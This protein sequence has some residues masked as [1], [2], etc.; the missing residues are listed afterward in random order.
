MQTDLIAAMIFT[1]EMKKMNNGLVLVVSGPAG[2]GKGTVNKILRETG[3]YLFSVSRTTRA[4]RP[5]ER[6]GVDY[7]FVTKEEFL[8]KLDEKDFLEY[9]EYCGNFYG[10]PKST[11]EEA[12]A[13]GKNV[14]LEI[15]VNGARQVKENCPEAV[16]IMLLPPSFAV[17]EQRLR[18]RGT[19]TEDKILK[20]LEQTHYELDQLSLYDYVVIN[21]DGGQKAAADDILSIVRA[22]KCAR[23]RNAEMQ[24]KYFEN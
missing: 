22:E 3:D 15:D 8:S 9:N 7:L 6:D 23:R 12:L 5:G 1:T 14:I 11:T 19:E 4:P 2:S 20:R 13:E 17:Q 21:G 16:L 18:G 10:T 24:Y